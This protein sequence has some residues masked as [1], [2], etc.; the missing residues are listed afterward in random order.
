VGRVGNV[1]IPAGYPTSAPVG[2]T[3]DGLPVDVQIIGPHLGDETTIRF[4]ELL[5]DVRGG[6][7]K[8]PGC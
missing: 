5:A 4:A 6:F 3:P 2:I 8:P 1:G 7:E